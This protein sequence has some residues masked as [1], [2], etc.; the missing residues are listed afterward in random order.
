GWQSAGRSDGRHRALDAGHHWVVVGQEQSRSSHHS[1]PDGLDLLEVMACRE[2]LERRGEQMEVRDDLLGRMR[3]AKCGKAHDVGEED[4]YVLMPPRRDALR[5]LKLGDRGRR[6]H[7]VEKPR[8][9]PA[10]LVHRR[11]AGRRASVP[12]LP[13]VTGVCWRRAAHSLLWLLLDE[14]LTPR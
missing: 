4:G 6:Q 12:Q 5:A 11:E 1:V 13:P 14:P 2:I 10:L 9:A 8:G 3:L 7:S